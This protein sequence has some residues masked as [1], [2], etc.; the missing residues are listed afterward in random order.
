VKPK[1]AIISAGKDNKYGHPHYRVIKNLENAGGLAGKRE[2]I[3]EYLEIMALAE[4][5][6]TAE[7]LDAQTLVYVERSVI[8]RVMDMLWID[9]LESMDH[10]RHGIGLRGYGQKDPLVEYQREGYGF[11]QQL[12]MMVEQQVAQM[13]T[14]VIKAQ[15][16]ANQNPAGQNVS[17][18]GEALPPLPP[19]DY[20]KIGRNDP[21]PCGGG[22]KWKKCHGIS[23]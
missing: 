23:L 7:K 9:H 1:L 14:R 2:A 16:E 6:A 8:L 12:L 19:G 18:S 3:R 11:F 21:C 22:K 4:L 20:S 13:I 17:L 15:A 5:N 10:L